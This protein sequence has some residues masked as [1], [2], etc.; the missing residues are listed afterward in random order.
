MHRWIQCLPVRTLPYLV[1]ANL[2]LAQSG[3]ARNCEYAIPTLILDALMA[4]LDLTN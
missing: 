4:E 2:W 3:V 1:E